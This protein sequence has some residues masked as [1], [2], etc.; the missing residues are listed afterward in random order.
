M[1]SPGDFP[2]PGIEPG[3]PAFQADT[4]TSEPPEKPE[5]LGACQKW[6]LGEIIKMPSIEIPGQGV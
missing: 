5:V 1:P 4:L 2:D 3:F 6:Q